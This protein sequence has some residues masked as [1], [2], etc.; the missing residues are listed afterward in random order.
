MSDLVY[1]GLALIYLRPLDSTF[2]E[3]VKTVAL[4]YLELYF[5]REETTMASSLSQIYGNRVIIVAFWV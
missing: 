4:R 2:M 3:Y 5:T 1:R